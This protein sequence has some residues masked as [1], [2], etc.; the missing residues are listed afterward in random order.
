MR[1][2]LAESLIATALSLLTVAP[3][4]PVLVQQVT[5]LSAQLRQ[6]TLQLAQVIRLP[7]ATPAIRRAG[8]ELVTALGAAPDL[9]P[10]GVDAVRAAAVRDHQGQVDTLRQ[11][12]EA[13]LLP[14]APPMLLVPAFLLGYLPTAAGRGFQGMDLLLQLERGAEPVLIAR[15]QELLTE[16]RAHN[17]ETVDSVLAVEA[18]LHHVGLPAP[19]RPQ[20]PD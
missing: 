14:E 16:L 8:G 9:S 3:G 4:H 15:G 6:A 2:L 10:E 13:A 1:A 11:A 20:T 19:A 12:L 18:L 7:L 5:A 17:R